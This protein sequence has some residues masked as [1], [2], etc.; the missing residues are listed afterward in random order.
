[1]NYLDIILIVLTLISA[2]A[3]FLLADISEKL[4]NPKWRICYLAPAIIA[5]FILAFSG[6]EKTL[7]GVYL[8]AAIL[9]AGVISEKKIIRRTACSLTAFGTI[10]SMA[11]CVTIGCRQYSYSADFKSGFE[12][13]KAHYVLAEHK[14]INWDYLYNEYFPQFK[15][16]DKTQSKAENLSLWVK[17]CA[18]FNDGHVNYITDNYDNDIRVVYN[19]VFGNDY[20][21]SLVTLSD[22]NTAAVNVEPNSAAAAAGIHNGTIVTSWDGVSP[23]KIETSALDYVIFADKD[24]RAFYRTLFCAGTGGDNVSVNFIDNNGE[25]QTALL[26]KLGAYY[27]SRLEKTLD[28]LNQGIDAGHL[29]WTDVSDTASVLRIKMMSADSKSDK[30]GNYD[31]LAD[32]MAEKLE[33]LKAQGKTRIILDLRS[34][35]GGSGGMVKALA[36]VFAPEGEYYYCSDAKWDAEN[37]RYLTDEN[38]RFVKECDNYFTGKGLWNGDIII[39]VN[40]QSVSAADHLCAVMQGM[41]NVT[42]MGFT[43]PNGSAQGIG[44]VAFSNGS[45]LAFSGS[46]LLDKNGD[47]FIDSS[48]EEIESGN[49]IDVVVPF[50]GE[51]IEALF[52]KGEDYLLSKALEY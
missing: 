6:F 44:G 14:D 3:L 36:S 23:D 5:T 46:L 15:A 19:N 8:G 10:V 22:G 33:E 38:G 18:E 9:C 27:S 41:P 32:E 2:A 21:L 37:N 26:P 11:L 51:A 47:V 48:A 39:L 52:V 4:K 16:V 42:I 20:G 43:E 24:N 7:L 25:E 31:A 34:N 17:F 40:A 12:S 35:S 50:D 30:S 28:I 49:G 45:S 13:M 1:M 29:T